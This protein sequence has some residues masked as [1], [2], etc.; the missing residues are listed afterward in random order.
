[1]AGKRDYYEVLGVKKN[2][3]EEELKKAYRKLALQYHPDRNKGNKEAEEKFKEISEAYAVLSD[4][5]KR[6]QYDQF[7]AAGFHKRYSQEDIFRGFDLGDLFKDLGFRSGDFF[8]TV[9]GRGGGRYQARPGGFGGYSQRPG[10]V[11]FESFFNGQDGF[12]SRPAPGNDMIAP[13]QITLKEAASGTKK[14]VR[15]QVH[16]QVKEVSVKTPP[17]I[18][19][20]KKLRLAGKGETSPH[21]GL[22]GD[23]YLKVEVLADPVFQREQD[24]LFVEKKVKFSEAV[25]GTTIEVPTLEGNKTVKVPAGTQ[26]NTKIRIKGYGMPKM[27]GGGKGNLYVKIFIETP[28]KLTKKQRELMENLAAE[29]L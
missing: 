26:G 29:G 12:Q 9:F 3:S 8:T 2:S 5:K 14:N 19:T 7:G 1:M 16:G 28:K 4:K 17:G 11:N 13:L 23:L 6:A 27:N 18:S 15:Y 21:G 25:L 22:P 24:D 10:G 20:G